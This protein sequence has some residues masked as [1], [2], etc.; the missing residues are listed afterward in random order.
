MCSLKDRF[1]VI[2]ILIILL[3]LWGYS[4]MKFRSKMKFYSVM[5]SYLR[6]EAKEAPSPENMLR[7]SGACL[8]LQRYK[9]AYNIYEQ[10]LPIYSDR[11]KIETNI[12]FCSNPIPGIH[13]PKNINQSWWHN[14]LLVRFGKKRYTFLTQEDHI[15]TE[16][17]MRLSRV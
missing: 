7:L 9:E 8:V 12:K 1:M 11:E 4:Y 16:A 10:L 17:L 3:F 13:Q 14:F 5:Y 15:K 2:L 6:E